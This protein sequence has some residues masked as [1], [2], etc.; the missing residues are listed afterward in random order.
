MFEKGMPQGLGLRLWTIM[1][2]GHSTLVTFPNFC[3]QDQTQFP[4][5][6]QPSSALDSFQEFQRDP[7]VAPGHLSNSLMAPQSLVPALALLPKALATLALP[8][9]WLLVVQGAQEQWCEP[10]QQWCEPHVFG[11][12]YDAVTTA[13]W[14]KPSQHQSPPGTNGSPSHRPTCFGPSWFESSARSKRNTFPNTIKEHIN[15]LSRSNQTDY[16]WLQFAT[17]ETIDAIDTVDTNDW[18]KWQVAPVTHWQGAQLTQMHGNKQVANPVQPSHS[19]WDKEPSKKPMTVAWSSCT[20]V[21]SL[22]DKRTTSTSAKPSTDISREATP[23]ERCHPH[24]H[25]NLKLRTPAPQHR[26]T[27]PNLNQK[28]ASCWISVGKGPDH[29]RRLRKQFQHKLLDTFVGKHLQ[30]SY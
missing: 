29:F 22:K 2:L 13:F 5:W 28:K 4:S 9:P 21:L 18:H 1:L 15:W 11:S 24:E 26:S 6:F 12:L 14:L 23:K 25:V 16:N 27:C 30:S 19:L 7:A 8:W 3:P 10:A 17:I 20:L